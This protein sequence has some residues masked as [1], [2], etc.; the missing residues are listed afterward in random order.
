M[1]SELGKEGHRKG[2]WHLV[3]VKSLWWRLWEHTVAPEVMAHRLLRRT[4][5]HRQ[6]RMACRETQLEAQAEDIP[7]PPSEWRWRGSGKTRKSP[8]WK[9]GH[10]QTG[11]YGSQRKPDMRR[12]KW[13]TN[14]GS[15]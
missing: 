12:D 15:A 10:R 9:Y 3:T 13:A 5:E 11:G 2:S 4:V 6:E 1:E 14:K 7:D 8:R